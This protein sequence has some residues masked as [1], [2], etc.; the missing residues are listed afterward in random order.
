VPD[1]TLRC[2]ALE[3]ADVDLLHLQHRLH[4]PLSTLR[5][6]IAE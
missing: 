2:G 4:G 3:L 5:V 1:L 6:G